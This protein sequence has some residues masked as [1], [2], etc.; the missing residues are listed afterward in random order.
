MGTGKR[1]RAF[2]LI[3]TFL[4]K[5]GIS[6]ALQICTPLTNMHTYFNCQDHVAK[7]LKGKKKYGE[8]ILFYN[9]NGKRNQKVLPL[10]Y[11]KNILHKIH[12]QIHIWSIPN[13][14]QKKNT[15]RQKMNKQTKKKTTEQVIQELFNFLWNIFISLAIIIR[16]WKD[17][18]PKIIWLKENNA[19]QLLHK[20]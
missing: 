2:G 9:S 19:F 18:I 15:P 6:F 7:M 1:M 11:L 10:S 5:K 20:C 3:G 17:I 16:L 8:K 4:P 13:W 14:K 12:N